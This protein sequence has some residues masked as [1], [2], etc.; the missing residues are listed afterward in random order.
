MVVCTP[1]KKARVVHMHKHGSNFTEIG[2]EL[3]FS[4]QTA[5][6]AWHSYLKNPD[7][8][9]KVPK[10]G[11]PKALSDYDCRIAARKIRSGQ[12]RDATD[13]HRQEFQHV[14]VTTVRRA[15][16]AMGLP[17]R[18]RRKK[19]LLTK[20]HIAKRNFWGRNH[21]KKTSRFWNKVVFTDESIFRL[22]G[23]DGIQWCRRGVGE[24]FDARNINQA[25]KHGGG[26]VTVWGCITSKGFGRLH[27]VEGNMN[28]FQYVDILEE[29]LMGTLQDYN[30]DV[31]NVIFQQD[32]DPKHTS[33][34][35]RDWLRSQGFKVLPW[36]PNSPDMNIIE[37]CWAYLAIR[38]R[39]RI[40]RPTTED[41]LWE[42]LQ[43]EWAQMGEGFR[44]RL[45]ESMP[46]RVNE[47]NARK[48]RHTRY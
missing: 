41:Q 40:P 34:H 32:N 14:G 35:T 25:P 30:L 26:K 36:P 38:I 37:H 11:R 27:R 4:K 18:R 3:G 20:I 12:A 21:Q 44:K 31:R 1:T 9:A 39:R 17:G 24:E 46:R 42:M 16:T 13:L 43:E 45:Y 22:F 10:P 47:L 2:K 7:F 15:L 23:S 48:G 6:R 29:S 33:G 5:S 28:R 19:F 8:Y